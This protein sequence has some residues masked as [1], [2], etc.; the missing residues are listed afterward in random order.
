MAT[1]I[2]KFLKGILQGDIAY[3]CYFSL[4]VSILYHLCQRKQKVTLSEKKEKLI[5]RLC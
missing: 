3:R 4:L 5:T 1:E 2:T